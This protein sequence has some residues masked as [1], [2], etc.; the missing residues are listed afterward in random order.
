MLI[1]ALQFGVMYVCVIKSYQ[2]LKAYEVA[3]LTVFTPFYISFFN[4]I[5]SRNISFK[6]IVAVSFAILGGLTIA[7][8]GQSLNSKIIGILLVQ[9]S[10]I[11]FGL[12]QLFYSRLNPHNNI[13]KEAS[14]F[15]LL[16]LGGF[17]VASLFAFSSSDF[18]NISLSYDQI[19]SLL[20]LGILPS[21][22]GFFLWNYGA[23]KY[24]L[25]H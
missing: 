19:I 13:Q 22:V 25:S 11:S 18:S 1:G 7:Y 15:S 2:Y 16:Y 24:Q 14:Y 5:S 9:G 3:L 23:K 8:K 12:G 20:Y 6:N 10:N 17:L 4:D 21:G